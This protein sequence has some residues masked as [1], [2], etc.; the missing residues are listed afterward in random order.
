MAGEEPPQSTIPG[1][2]PQG[3]APGGLCLEEV[4]TGETGRTAQQLEQRLPGPLSESQDSYQAGHSPT[5]REAAE[6]QRGGEAPQCHT[7]RKPPRPALLPGLSVCLSVFVKAHLPVDSSQG[8]SPFFSASGEGVTTWREQRGLC[9]GPP[10]GGG[11][12]AR[13]P[14]QRQQPL[15]C[16]QS[17]QQM[18]ELGGAGR[19]PALFSLPSTP[20]GGTQQAAWLCR[21]YLSTWELKKLAHSV[22]APGILSRGSFTAACGGRCGTETQPESRPGEA[23][24]SAAPCWESCW[25]I[26]A[27]AGEWSGHPLPRGGAGLRTT[28]QLAGLWAQ[29]ALLAVLGRCRVRRGVSEALAG[30]ESKAISVLSAAGCPCSL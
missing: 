11:Q 15:L 10:R 6:A 29:P 21:I 26:L 4:G 30:R 25:G 16:V 23:R 5:V 18:P 28:R 20:C 1:L 9:P 3:W 17:S 7:A 8:P 22:P 14:G 2:C 24:G 27:R 12:A 19:P 13:S